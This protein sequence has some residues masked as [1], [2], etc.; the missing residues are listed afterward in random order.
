MIDARNKIIFLLRKKKLFVFVGSVIVI[1]SV[2]NH[3]E[4]QYNII[5]GSNLDS[6]IHHHLKYESQ[7]FPCKK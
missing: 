5:L 4:V 1:E 3:V 7:I 2:R 6:Y